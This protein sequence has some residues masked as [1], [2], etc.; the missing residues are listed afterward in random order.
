L[1]F[2]KTTLIRAQFP[3]ASI[4][5]LLKSSVFLALSSDPSK[6]ADMAREIHRTA[7]VVVIR[8]GDVLKT[9]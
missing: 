5:N 9:F 3:E 1:I 2:G 8:I 7:S 6:L 4:I